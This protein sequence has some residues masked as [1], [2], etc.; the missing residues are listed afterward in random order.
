MLRERV[1]PAEKCTIQPARICA[2]LKW[3]APRGVNRVG[4]WPWGC[5]SLPGPVTPSLKAAAAFGTEGRRRQTEPSSLPWLRCSGSS[6]GSAACGIQRHVGVAGAWSFAPSVK[7]VCLTLRV[8]P[9]PCCPPAIAHGASLS[10]LRIEDPVGQGVSHPAAPPG[11]NPRRRR[12]SA[13]QAA[14]LAAPLPTWPRFQKRSAAGREAGARKWRRKVLLNLSQTNIEHESGSSHS[15]IRVFNV[16][17]PLAVRRIG[18]PGA[19]QSWPGSP[20]WP[21]SGV[22]LALLLAGPVTM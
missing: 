21:P 3:L 10:T 8:V 16:R 12:A 4:R 19:A 15:A 11:P 17:G 9:R 22:C 18:E 14:P 5:S 7:V 13:T 6:Q 1:A 2:A 20:S